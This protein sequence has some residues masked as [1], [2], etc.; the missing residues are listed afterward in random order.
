LIEGIRN[1]KISQMKTSEDDTD[2]FAKYPD[3]D[4]PTGLTPTLRGFMQSIVILLGGLRF[5][6][7]IL[8][9]QLFS[10]KIITNTLKRI[11]TARR[12]IRLP[13]YGLQK[14]PAGSEPQHHNIR[15]QYGD[16]T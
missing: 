1:N 16:E 11:F 10:P 15:P 13:V 4:F 14:R 12:R 2:V 7:L 8:R 9:P 5:Q 3:V 6:V